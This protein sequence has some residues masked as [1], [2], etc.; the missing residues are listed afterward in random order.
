MLH[1][2]KGLQVSCFRS[3]CITEVTSNEE[4]HSTMQAL[5][6]VGTRGTVIQMLTAQISPHTV[7]Y[8]HCGVGWGVGV[9]T[10]PLCDP[11]LPQKG[12]PGKLLGG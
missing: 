10:C 8:T 2:P 4:Q 12:P 1:F 11:Q 3:S 5:R 9:G 6:T 7:L